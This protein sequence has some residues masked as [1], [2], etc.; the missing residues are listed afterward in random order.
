MYLT[1]YEE[2]MLAGEFGE[3]KAKAI[4]VIVKVGEALGAEDLV[5]V[6]HVHISG[7]SYYSVGEAGLEFLK[8]MATERVAVYT[9]CNPGAVDLTGKREMIL[10]DE[11][12]E[13]QSE[14]IGC[15]K[16]M[17]VDTVCTCAPY[18]VR[19]PARG[20]DL[21]WGESNAVLYANSVL[22]AK[23]NRLGGPLTVLAALTG[24]VPRYGMHLE[25]SRRP[26]VRVKATKS[27][28][29]EYEWALFG[30][31]LGAQVKRGVPYVEH[32]PPNEQ[33][34]RAFLAGVGTSSEIAHVIINGVSPEANVDVAGLERVEIELERDEHPTV[35]CDAVILGCPHMSLDDMARFYRMV[36]SVRGKAKVPVYLMTY[37]DVYSKLRESGALNLLESMGVTVLRGACLVVSRIKYRRVITDSSK[38][39]HYMTTIQGIEAQG[40][41]LERIVEEVFTQ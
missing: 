31:R 13:K 22:G 35:E 15:L 11:V 2:R 25:D 16:R 20:E 21:A 27:P 17:G 6:S 9:T 18:Y 12:V 39:A 33:S 29:N 34:L 41:P 37:E 36:K 3:V 28:E 24:R 7:V 23:T 10:D 1:R 5:K 40:M 32:T 26:T 8:E 14:I 19:M 30:Y 4:K 38:A